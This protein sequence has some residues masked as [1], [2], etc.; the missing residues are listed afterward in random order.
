MKRDAAIDKLSEIIGA[1]LHS[2]A[3]DYEVTIRTSEGKVNK[4]W[5]GHVFERH[6][7]MQLNSS[8]NPNGGSWELK[9]IPLRYD[10]AGNLIIKETMAI[11][12]INPIDVMA[13]DFLHSHLYDKLNQLLIVTRIVGETFDAPQTIHS[14][15]RYNLTGKLLF[16]VK[17]DYDLVRNRLL[18]TNGDLTSLSGRMGTYIQPRTKGPGHGSTSRAFYARKNFL[19]EVTGL[20]D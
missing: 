14:V 8:R 18:K 12:M 4:G 19:L 20:N 2:L 6:L 1:D 17:D 13:K 16:A 9:T 15:V 7:G 10:R 3:R 11:T 5:P